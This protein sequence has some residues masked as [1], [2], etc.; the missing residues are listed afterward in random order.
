MTIITTVG[1]ITKDFELQ[2]SEGKGIK[3]VK[4]SLVV[5]EWVNNKPKETYFNCTVF[6]LDAERLVKAKAK[7]GSLL[8]ISGKF[9]TT[10]FERNNGDKGYSLDIIVHAWSYIP[11]A[12]SNG[13]NGNG[14]SEDS[15]T[16]SPDTGEL[17]H[18]TASGAPPSG[19][20]TINLDD[21][22][23]PF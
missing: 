7:K 21:E 17:G 11:G 6:G 10:E 20:E 19:H 9:G 12:S 4:F 15:S 14:N 8:Q 2:T 13:K 3:Y 5:N 16:Q 23:Y 18:S 22:D 1:R